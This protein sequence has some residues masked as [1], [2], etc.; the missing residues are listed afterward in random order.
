MLNALDEL[1]AVSCPLARHR[2]AVLTLPAVV[3]RQPLGVLA[4]PFG[5][6]LRHGFLF[7]LLLPLAFLGFRAAVQFGMGILNFAQLKANPLSRE[8]LSKLMNR[9]EWL[10]SL[11]LAFGRDGRE[12]FIA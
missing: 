2:V 11:I 10:S 9:I 1:S 12:R 7:R 4:I 5:H 6:A 8:T 3:L